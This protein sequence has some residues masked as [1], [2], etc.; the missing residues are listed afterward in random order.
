M[1]KYI[2]IEIVSD[3]VLDVIFV[4]VY[5]KKNFQNSRKFN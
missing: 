1:R 3:L 2:E 5:I 4:C